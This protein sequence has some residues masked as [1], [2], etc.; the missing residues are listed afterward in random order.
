MKSFLSSTFLLCLMTSLSYSQII[1]SEYS[2]SNLNQ[3][4]D[5]FN[6][7]EDWIEIYN[8]S[9]DAFDIGGWGISD[10]ESKPQKWLFPEGTMIEGSSHI[11]VWCSGRDQS[12]GGHY[13]TNFKISQTKGN[14]FILLS[15]AA[16]NI[17]ESHLAEITLLG[18]SRVKSNDGSWNISVD[19]TP[20]M[21]NSSPSFVKYTNEP[22][23]EKEAGYYEGTQEISIINNEP[24]SALRYS[25][26]GWA[27]T[28][29]SPLYTGPITVDETTVIKARAF[30]DAA[31]IL[32]GKINFK[33][34]LINENFTVPVI[35][36][37]ADSVQMLAN[38]E[39]EIR[40]IGSIEYFNLDKEL[41][42]TS[43]G[44]LN[45][46]GQ[47]SWVNDHRSIDWVSRDEMGYSKALNEKLFSYSDRDEYQRF[48]MR[49]SGDDNYPAI[50]DAVHEGSCHIR[51][52]YVQQLAYEGNLKLDIRAVSRTVVFLNGDYWGLYS[53][54]ERPVDH[55][56]TEYY[57]DQ[58]KYDL[59]Y[60]LTWGET[61]TEYGGGPALADWQEFR[62]FIM[63]NDMGEA[64]NYQRVK[65]EMQLQGLIDYFLINL[66]AVSSDWLNYNTGWW[67]GLNPDGDHKKWG[68]ILW[69]NDAT[70]D[71][72]IN[73]SGVPNTNPDAVP[74]DLDDIS[75]YMDEFFSFGGFQFTQ[76]DVANC[77]T[78]Q[79]QEC[80]YPA[81]DPIVFKV[82]SEDFSCCWQGWDLDCENAYQKIAS[83]DIDNC[84]TIID[85]SCPYPADDIYVLKVMS[86]DEHCCGGVWDSVCENKYKLFSSG[87]GD[88]E[89]GNIYENFG[90]HE[91]IL[92]KLIDE[93]PEFK[94]MFY[95]RQADLNNTVFSCDN[96]LTL[97]DK[98][99][100]DIIIEMPKQIDRW[101]GSMAEWE[102]NINLMRDFIEDRCAL[103]D[104]GV[105]ECYDLTGPYDLTLQVEPA[106][107]GRIE[108]NSLEINSFPWSGNYFGNMQNLIDADAFDE[109]KFVRWESKNGNSIFPNELEEKAS[110]ELIQGD[111]LVAVFSLITS[112]DDPMEELVGFSAYPSPT[113]NILNISYNINEGSKVNIKLVNSLGQD[114][115]Q[116]ENGV[117]TSPNVTVN[118]EIDMRSIGI[119]AGVYYVV[120]QTEKNTFSKKVLFFN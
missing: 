103:M 82:M 63:D 38:G 10:K 75:D 91:K 13:H 107:A 12:R 11:V 84:K 105:L 14:E 3:F 8:T 62:D 28:P 36:I 77:M 80:P 113:D 39:G 70:F 7:Y 92:Y 79:E 4:L 32:P 42:S 44:E 102:S 85:G 27:P 58:G 111:T 41:S 26:N 78:V 9:S 30:S 23:I 48:M 96:M 94:Q 109:Y 29:T 88:G 40:P 72:Y 95:A 57:Y 55:D 31:N 20:G 5:D 73:Y 45:R 51:D 117:F 25:T 6:K 93:N 98:M 65:D 74:C 108:L 118:K 83:L 19:P 100:D 120:L 37:A 33:T 24:N 15:D 81:D 112:T 61:W 99:V 97:F 69:D 22:T 50:N 67:R 17:I 52:E 76:D 16:G 104:D 106:G 89:K 2:A 87:L 90:L 21:P 43:Y 114:I 59:Q 110:I 86:V 46:H 56:Y 116:I 53:P 66:A 34:L 49:A 119:D 101:G 60:I 18:H 54:R 1:I 115:Y 68:Y 47:D 71:Y 35:S 64:D